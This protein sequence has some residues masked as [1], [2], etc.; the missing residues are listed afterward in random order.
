MKLKKRILLEVL[1]LSFGTGITSLSD[2]VKTY[3]TNQ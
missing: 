1:A 2:F 3:S